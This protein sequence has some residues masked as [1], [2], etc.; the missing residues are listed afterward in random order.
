MV[1]FDTAN[2]L[3]ATEKVRLKRLIYIAIVCGFLCH[4][5]GECAY[6]LT[7]TTPNMQVS[8]GDSFQIPIKIDE[9]E[10]LAG[11]RLVVKYDADMLEFEQSIQAKAVES[12][13]HI[14]NNKK[15]G[16]L[17]IVMAGAKGIKGKNCPLLWIQF[18]A[19][20]DLQKKHELKLEVANLQL[21]DEQ[22]SNLKAKTKMNSI[23]VLPADV[24]GH[25]KKAK[26]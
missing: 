13:M 8:S 15:P 16:V 14:S 25:K 5:L 4:W 1:D 26:N 22:L 21:M 6:A 2:N 20:P 19:K 9:V 17:I 18:K 7:L 12:L 24:Q 3:K 23:V 10:N 11:L